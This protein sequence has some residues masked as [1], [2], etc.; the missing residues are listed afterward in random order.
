MSFRAGEGGGRPGMGGP[1]SGVGAR[2]GAGAGR[3]GVGGPES[4]VGFRPGAGAG[5]PGVGGP[6]SGIG[7]RPGAGAGRPGVGGPDSGIGFRPGAGAGAPGVGGPDSGIGFRPGA[8]AGAA[9][10]PGAYSAARPYGTYHEPAAALDARGDAF[11]AGA[12]DFPRYDAAGIGNY[13]N[14]WR[15]VNVNNGNLYMNPGYGATAAMLGLA[16]APA[17]Y[18]YGGN[19]VT[20][21]NTVYV[22]GDSAGSTQEYTDQAS[23]VASAGAQDPDPNSQWLP[24]GVFAIVEGDATTSDDSFQIA[25]NPQGVIRGNYYNKQSNQMLPISG[26]VDKSTQKAAWTIDGDKMPVYEAGVANL[27]KDQTPLLV[28]TDQ[29]PHQMTLIRLEQPPA[30]Q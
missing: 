6:D 14:A 15:P 11:R 19:V 20:Q 9:G 23:Q 27:T 22:N 21:G 7:F 18:D 30:Q 17:A 16:A 3:P 1:E 10:L 28:H 2:P 12:Y 5:R 26:S 24:M 13:P 8:G 29:G 25:V 4:G